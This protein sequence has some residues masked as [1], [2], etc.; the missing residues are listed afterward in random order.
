MSKDKKLIWQYNPS[1]TERPPIQPLALAL[2]CLVFIILI[3]V[4][5]IMD[6]RRI[7]KPSPALWRIGE[8]VL[9]AS[10]KVWLKKT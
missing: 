4:M 7:E 5:G 8:R 10:S 3:L 6:I 2:V 9:S 1:V